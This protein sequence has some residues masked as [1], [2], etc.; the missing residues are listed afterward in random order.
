MKH[1]VRTSEAL[2]RIPC[3]LVRICNRFVSVTHFT[4][5]VSTCVRWD[6]SITQPE[7]VEAARM[8]RIQSLVCMC[9]VSTSSRELRAKFVAESSTTGQ[10]A[11]AR[12]QLFAVSKCRTA[13]NTQHRGANEKDTTVA[14][15]VVIANPH[16]T[17]HCFTIPNPHYKLQQPA[18]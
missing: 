13:H 18:P 12:S 2:F 15:K 9:W 17:I 8:R 1:P 14:P 7:H 16:Y 10:A 4:R 11:F 6:T 3:W 5:S